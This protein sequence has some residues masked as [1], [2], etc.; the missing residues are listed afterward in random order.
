MTGFPALDDVE[1]AKV[2]LGFLFSLSAVAGYLAWPEIE[3]W[4]RRRCSR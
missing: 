2:L 3:S 1:L 4:W